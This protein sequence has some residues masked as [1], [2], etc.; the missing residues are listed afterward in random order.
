M[1]RILILIFATIAN[2]NL[3]AQGKP[4]EDSC[5]YVGK[6]FLLPISFQVGSNE[7]NNESKIVLEDLYQFIT[8]N[9]LKIEISLHTDERSNSKYLSSDTCLTCERAEKIK[10]YLVSLG[11]RPDSIVA[12]GYQGSKPYFVDAKTEEQHQLNRRTVVT[13][14]K[15]D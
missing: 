6:H 13:I 12:K 3:F 15:N 9:N 2:L 14:L 10:D 4:N 7:L 5:C 8:K 1:K 11:A